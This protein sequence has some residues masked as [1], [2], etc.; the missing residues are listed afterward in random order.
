VW[1]A[2]GRGGEVWWFDPTV[3]RVLDTIAV[4]RLKHAGFGGPSYIRSVAVGT[5]GVW[6]LDETQ[7]AA[8]RIDPDTRKVDLTIRQA[9]GGAVHGFGAGLTGDPEWIVAGLGRAW[10]IEPLTPALNELNPSLRS[11]ASAVK[12]PTSNVDSAARLD[13]S[14]LA[15]GDGA[16]WLTSFVKAELWRVDPRLASISEVIPVGR[17][18]LGLAVDDNGVWVAN[19]LDGTV[20]RV[21]PQ[22]NKVVA[23]IHLGH[24]PSWV[25]VGGGRVWVSVQP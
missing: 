19:S 15:V 25:A 5:G 8:F 16:L 17:G 9:V 23:T 24:L 2:T 7:T 13:P 3:N 14:A 12:L 22:T 20:A 11:V 1:V 10:T 21:D 6:A 4:P 18:A